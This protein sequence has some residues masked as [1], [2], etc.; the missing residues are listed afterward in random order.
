MIS[1]WFI[2]RRALA[3]NILSIGQGTGL[4]L[5]PLSAQF[6]IGNWGW[7]TAWAGLGL[8]TLIIGILP[9]L[10]LM[11]RRPE[12]IGLTP[13]P[14]KQ[15]PINL[16]S[17]PSAIQGLSD[18]MEENFTLSEALKT[19]AFW[20]LAAFS[21]SGFMVQS[22]V[23]LHQ[24]PHLIGQGI[25]PSFAVFAASTFALSQV[26]GGIIW[27]TLA[28]KF[29]V[30]YLLAFAGL[31]AGFLGFVAA[32]LGFTGFAFGFAAAAFL[33]ATR[34]ADG[35]LLNIGT[36]IETSVNDL[37]QVMAASVDG[38][39]EPSRESAKTGEIRR[40]ALNPAEAIEALDWSPST[41]LA[42]GVAETLTWFADRK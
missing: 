40:S 19:K 16:L 9:S 31:A 37:Y 41:K 34:K 28:S 36:G 32:A 42:A 17:P 30:R 3:L 6:L 4:A 2:R 5:M 18:P 33:A 13:D 20:I 26:I 39:E 22:G 12:D 11:V 1:N 21:V 14:A 29:K 24:V 23:S 15:H 25:D 10:L 35:R 27:S 38:P 8:Y 7:R